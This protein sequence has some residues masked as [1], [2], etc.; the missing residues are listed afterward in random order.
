MPFAFSY[1]C[2]LLQRLE[3]NRLARSGLRS[4]AVIIQEWFRGHQ[5]LLHR[6]D[7]KSAPLLSA[8]LPEK[9]T[10]R[11]YFIRE[12][13]LQTIIGR[14]LYLGRSRIAE[15]GRWTNSGAA[16]DLADCVEG[17]LKQTVGFLLCWL[18]IICNMWD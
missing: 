17:I 5:G 6:D 9:R 16:V 8:L 15:L 12:K 13:K 18:P 3:D 2:D 11:V 7:H 10:D 14:A 1:V 4:N